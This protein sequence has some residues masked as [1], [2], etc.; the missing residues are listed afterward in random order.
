M[1]K[2]SCYYVINQVANLK[3]DHRIFKL[4]NYLI[5]ILMGIYI[6][7]NPFPHMTSI[8][9]ICFYGSVII[10][11]ILI[12]FKKT[13][14]SFETPLLVPFILFAGWVF[15]GLFFALD[16]GNSVHDFYSHLLRYLAIY[17]I[18]INFF[19][20]KKRFVYLA[21]I[22]IISSIT[23]SIWG[24]FY[25]YHIMGYNW[26]TRFSY[27]G[28]KGFLGY[29]VSGNSICVLVI[30]SI[31][32]SLNF[33]MDGSLRRKTTLV[34]CLIPQ[35]A[36]VFLV[37]SKGAYIALLLSL[38]ILLWKNKKILL[39]VLAILVIV[40]AMLP[41]KGRL[42]GLTTTEDIFGS[43]RIKMMFTTLEIV[44]D[45]PIIGIGFG[46]ETYGKKVDLRM[47]NNRAPKKY[48]QGGQPT[49]APHN[50]L[51]NILVRVGIVGLVLFLFIIFVFVK[52]CWRCVRYGKDD[53]VKKWELCIGS[54]FLAFVVIG[55]FEQMFHHVTEMILFTT[56]SMGT[57][58]WR[59]N[60]KK[61][62]AL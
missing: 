38:I 43:R 26:A 40:T 17:F 9:E 35:I 23:Y 42:S 47:Y 53:F 14:F 34:F 59:L 19:N 28:A 29:E 50:I 56:L 54:A 5:P 52:M 45:Y 8:K 22:I 3:E 31:L 12:C 36:L 37:Q 20:S 25:F 44:K 46:N 7:I 62:V 2:N 18:L 32:L 24:L 61:D 55:M 30:F 39:S 4:L 6:F 13:D 1:F 11:L 16:K 57:I 15:A 10:V 27:G 21:R 41:I 58:L 49:G 48:R 60:K 33:F 51:L